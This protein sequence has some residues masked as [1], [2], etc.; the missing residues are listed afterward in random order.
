ME[1]TVVIGTVP[2]NIFVNKVGTYSTHKELARDF[3]TRFLDQM[4]HGFSWQLFFDPTG[5]FAGLTFIGLPPRK[6]QNEISYFE[7]E[8]CFQ[9]ATQTV[10][11]S[12]FT[13]H[14]R[15]KSS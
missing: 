12:V 11:S 10:P 9:R 5:K 14:S 13:A 6:T 8:S 4:G 2:P 3:L 1:A 15:R 7:C